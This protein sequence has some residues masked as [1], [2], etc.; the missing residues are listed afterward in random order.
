MSDVLYNLSHTPNFVCFPQAS[1]RCSSDANMLGEMMFGS[2]A[3]SYKGSTLKIHQIR[4]DWSEGCADVMTDSL[5]WS[6]VCVFSG[7]LHSWCSVKCLQPEQVA[8][9][10]AA[11]TRKQ[12]TLARTLT[13]GSAML[14]CLIAALDCFT[15]CRTVWSSSV[16]TPTRSGPSRTLWPTA[17]WAA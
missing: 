11:W 17:S 5:C 8:A 15:D 1:S 4:W 6:G 10:T 2:V 12:R 7:L 14:R 13:A 9:P 16:R 3:M